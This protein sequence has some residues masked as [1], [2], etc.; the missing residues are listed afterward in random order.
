MSAPLWSNCSKMRRRPRHKQFR[1]VKW[2][3]KQN[4]VISLKHKKS[5]ILT[6]V[7]HS[8]NRVQRK[9][10]YSYIVENASLYKMKKTSFERKKESSI[11]LGQLKRSWKC[12]HSECKEQ[13][14]LFL[15]KNTIKC[16]F[17]LFICVLA[18]DPFFCVALS[19]ANCFL[20]SRC[21]HD[22]S[23]ANIKR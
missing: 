10:Y 20:L 11:H 12:S 14:P 23:S 15:A 19:Q 4:F 1:G 7:L 21:K 5:H 13:N 18:S 2:M 22:G 16:E 3:C 9:R 6:L 17:M 8:A